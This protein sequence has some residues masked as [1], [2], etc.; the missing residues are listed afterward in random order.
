MLD[1]HEEILVA[2]VIR[3]DPLFGF[4]TGPLEVYLLLEKL[5]N[6]TRQ[7][8]VYASACCTYLWFPNFRVKAYMRVNY[9]R[10]DI[11]SI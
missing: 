10:T 6:T 4:I 2:I 9:Y 7:T 8:C 11:Y 3:R 1:T 5:Q